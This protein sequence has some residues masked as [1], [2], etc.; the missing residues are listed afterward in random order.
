MFNV[1]ALETTRAC[2]NRCKYCYG[3]GR[4]TFGNMSA[5][6]IQASLNYMQSQP[7]NHYHISLLGG[8]PSL[9]LPFILPLIQKQKDQYDKNIT[10]SLNTNG[11]LFNE[12]MCEELKIFQPHLAISLD[13]VKPLHDFNRIDVHGNGTYDR[14]IEKL[15][16]LL[17][18]FPDAFCQSTF[19]PETIHGL[20]DSYFLAKD[21]GFK[22]WYWAPDLYE[23]KWQQIHFDI[24]QEQLNIIAK[25]YFNQNIIKYRGFENFQN[26]NPGNNRFEENSHCLLIHYDGIAKISRLNATIVDLNEDSNWF[27]GNILSGI[28]N[29]KIQKWEKRYGANADQLYYSYNSKNVCAVCPANNICFDTKNPYLYKIKCEQPRIQCEQ[30]RAIIQAALSFQNQ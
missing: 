3:S 5:E 13:G 6:V 30:K 12:K 10:I 8:E 15:P 24:L 9:R 1:L 19:T 17:D 14:L 22:E 2:T 28:D 7:S 25:D 21:L 29:E 26:R 20:S 11:L 4:S 23:S 16:M 18:Y 27:I